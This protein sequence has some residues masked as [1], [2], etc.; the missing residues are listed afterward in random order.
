MRILSALCVT[1]L[2][3]FAGAQSPLSANPTGQGL[4]YGIPGG[5]NFFDLTVNTTVTLQAIEVPVQNAVGESGSLQ[6]W[7][8]T[9]THVGFEATATGW[10][11]VSTGP[12]TSPGFGIVAL[13]CQ[14]PGVVLQPGTY[15]FAVRYLGVNWQFV[16]VTTFQTFST[17]EMTL[18]NGN[19]Q[20]TPFGAP[21]GPF[22]FGGV[23]YLGSQFRI[24]INYGVGNVPHACAASANY[25]EGCYKVCASVYQE[26]TS[27]AAASA[28]LQ[29]QGLTLVPNG[30]FTGYDIV[31][32]VG[33][34]HTPDPVN[35][36][37]VT[38]PAGDDTEHTQALTLPFTYP[39]DAGPVVT[40]NLFIHDNG[41]FSVGS[42]NVLPGGPNFYPEEQQFL[43]APETGWWM[44]HDFNMTEA[45]SGTIKYEEDLAAGIIYITYE[46][47]ESYPTTAL[48][49]STV[50]F[51]IDTNSGVVNY[52]FQT[53]DAVGGSGVFGGDDWLV[54]WGPGGPSPNCGQFD[55]A[56]LTSISANLPEQFPLQLDATSGRP[57]LGT[58]VDLTTSNETTNPGV[59]INF[60]STV[61]IPA[62]GF[63]LGIVGM[64]GCN[65]LL[66]INAGVGNVITNIM[67]FGSMTISFAV[68]NNPT[69][70]GLNIYSQSVWLDGAANAFGAII[71]NGVA[72]T[73]GNY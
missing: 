40:L 6:L 35:N 46:G 14:T 47:V 27:A 71:S 67:G 8:R 53:V 37:V 73:I 69:L 31:P 29:G 1:G 68:P 62:P 17:A 54:G 19:T 55:I 48:N 41:Y 59:G 63:G 11:Q 15:G 34:Y 20:V 30:T 61:Q 49:P 28:A 60:L 57:I 39:T 7:Q 58:T 32:G 12:Y 65:A 33:V 10:T 50:Q 70:P 21:L 43:N 51:Q 72:L 16:G 25:G 66:D 44:W 9:G 4:T 3:S 42:N 52:V 22:A 36:V 2:V 13:S 45:G 23:N 18:S 56:T 64:P 5:Q 26:F 38:L 24:N